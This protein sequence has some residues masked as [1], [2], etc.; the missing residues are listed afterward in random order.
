MPPKQSK[1]SKSSEEAPQESQ[2]RATAIRHAKLI[3]E[4]KDIQNNVLDNIIAFVD[5]PSTSDAD[6]ANPLTADVA[7]FKRGLRTFQQRDYDDLITERNISDKCGYTLCHRP[8]KK[9]ETTATDRI[10]WGEKGTELKIVPR[11]ELEKWC[12]QKCAERAMFVRVQLNESPAWVVGAK[13]EDI[14][15]LDEARPKGQPKTSEQ[16]TKSLAPSKQDVA[17]ADGI[18]QLAIRDGLNAEDEEALR[19]IQ[20]LVR[21]RGRP[22]HAGTSEA[23]KLVENKPKGTPRPPKPTE[24]RDAGAIEGFRPNL[25]TDDN[26]NDSSE[27]NILGI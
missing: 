7:S 5:L 12:S 24:T 27:P 3:Q 18:R 14:I 19:R 17:L 16:P 26:E 6:P 21:E 15:L 1:E 4:Q 13:K 25:T 22:D 9:D 10:L 23:V 20:Q 8:K 11:A 2:I